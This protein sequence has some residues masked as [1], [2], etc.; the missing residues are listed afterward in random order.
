MGKYANRDRDALKE[1]FNGRLQKRY[2]ASTAEVVSSVF[3]IMSNAPLHE[4][5]RFKR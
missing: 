1:K 3:H 2:E 4:S 5:K